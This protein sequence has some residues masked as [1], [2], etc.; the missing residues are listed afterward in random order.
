MRLETKLLADGLLLAVKGYV[1]KAIASLQSRL[2]D[3]DARIKSIPAGERGPQGDR[4]ERGEKG[5]DGINGRD[6]APGERGEKGADGINGR[7]GA[8]G[9]RGEKGA[10]GI[11]GRDG[12]PG[13]R[14]EKGADGIN[15]RDGANV[16]VKQVSELI[17][18]ALE[19]AT[20]DIVTRAAALIP[21][22]ANGRDGR[23]GT[24]GA[25]GRPGEKGIDGQNGRDGVDGFGFDDMSFEHD[26]LRAGVL[27]F[28]RGDRIKEFTLR[29]PALID[30]GVWR[31]GVSLEKGDGVTY[32]GSYWI[33]Q[34]DNNT[35]TPGNDSG[36][37]RLAVK[38]GRDGKL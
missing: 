20:P 19:L 2:D 4:G 17:A 8:P 12:A 14:G 30:C 9:E 31:A 1:G 16:D 36:A 3:L 25:P 10:D 38:K 5:A 11:N 34:K 6:G 18:K 33:S 15:G 7:D 22:P 32:A 37:W 28:Q 24:A 13:E 21:T 35:D 29:T 23:D 26:G 27:R